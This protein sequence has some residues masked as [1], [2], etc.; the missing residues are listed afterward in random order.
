VTKLLE[1]ETLPKVRREEDEEE[2]A[3]KALVAAAKR[4]RK[5]GREGWR[6]GS[7]WGR[8]VGRLLFNDDDTKE[9]EEEEEEEDEEEEVVEEGNEEGM[10]G[11]EGGG[12]GR[13]KRV[14]EAREE[15]WAEAEHEFSVA[16]EWEKA[17]QLVEL[18]R[19]KRQEG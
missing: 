13:K 19:M 3:E 6:G 1:S 7:L 8:F 12:G 10:R 9:K 17:R 14:K 11:G 18:A 2:A 16:P 5:E 15:A 4:R